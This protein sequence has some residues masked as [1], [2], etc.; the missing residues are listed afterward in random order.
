MRLLYA[1]FLVCLLNS[2]LSLSGQEVS[3][4]LIPPTTI[5]KQV[6]LDIRVGIVNNDSQKQT[7]D[8][9]LYLN[10]KKKSALLHHSQEY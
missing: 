5:T 3:L 4:T 2:T 10:K 7:L 9:F 1:I 8:I 6:D